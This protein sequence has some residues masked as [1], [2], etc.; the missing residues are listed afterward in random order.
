LSG[1]QEVEVELVCTRATREFYLDGDDNE[2]DDKDKDDERYK[3]PPNFDGFY[4]D[5]P[6]DMGDGFEN[7][8]DIPSLTSFLGSRGDIVDAFDFDAEYDFD[9]DEEEEADD[10]C[11]SSEDT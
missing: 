5:K 4:G 2:H 7:H 1:P 11:L 10:D 8:P 9:D 6:N 3:Q